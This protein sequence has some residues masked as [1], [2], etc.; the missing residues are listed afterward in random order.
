MPFSSVKYFLKI[1]LLWFWRG[2]KK[3]LLP[4]NY[5]NL[6]FPEQSR[7]SK[8]LDSPLADGWNCWLR[9]REWCFPFVYPGKLLSP[10]TA[11]IL[12]LLCGF[13]SFWNLDSCAF[14]WSV[15]LLSI[16]ALLWVSPLGSRRLKLNRKEALSWS[17]QAWGSLPDGPC[18]HHTCHDGRREGQEKRIK[19]HYSWE[20]QV[21]PLT[22][23]V[24]NTIFSTEEK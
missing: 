10:V 13:Q 20:S 15:K 1:C 5:S 11:L 3:S 23:S 6:G 21:V 17:P 4:W 2:E 24:V 22:S 19:D 8:Q 9:C 16:G 12:I 14:P 18:T 7:E